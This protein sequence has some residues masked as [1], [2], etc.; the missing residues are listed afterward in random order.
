MENISAQYVT[1]EEKR[2]LDVGE[3]RCSIV[4]RARLMCL[5]RN[6]VSSFG[7]TALVIIVLVA[8]APAFELLGLFSFS[9]QSLSGSFKSCRQYKKKREKETVL[10]WALRLEA[11]TPFE[12][13]SATVDLA[14]PFDAVCPERQRPQASG[15]R[16]H[17]VVPLLKAS[18]LTAGTACGYSSCLQFI[19][20]ASKESTGCN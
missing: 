13:E 7:R 15:P 6:A 19:V 5:L 4:R 2:I 12:E 1:V 9:L 8:L 16:V 3:V 11:D 14:W 18:S 10:P 17:S 20:T